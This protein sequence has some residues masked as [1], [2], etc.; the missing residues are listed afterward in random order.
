MPELK[1]NFLKGKMNK[2]LDER[3]V[4]NGEYRDA[5]NI[6]ISTSEGSDVGSAQ[7]LKGNTKVTILNQCGQSFMGG[8]ISDNAISVGS[9]VD[10]NDSK[11][12]NF[13]YRAS[14]LEANGTYGSYTVYTGVRSDVITEYTPDV[15]S[16]S[17]VTFPILTDIYDVRYFADEQTTASLIKGLPTQTI[18]PCD[19]DSDL[20]AK[21]I[22]PGMRVQLMSPE[23]IDYY[24]EENKVYVSKVIQGVLSNE[25]EVELTTSQ[26]IP[27]YT[28]SLKDSGFVFKFSSDKILNFKT[29]TTEIESNTNEVAKSYT[30][31]NNIITG[32]NLINDILFFTDGRNEPKKVSINNFKNSKNSITHH[33]K[34]R[35]KDINGTAY[36]YSLKEE[37]ITVIKRNP[38]NSIDVELISTN[39]PSTQI[40]DEL[41]E[42]TGFTYA[43]TT[44]SAIL[45]LDNIDSNYGDLF[46]LTNDEGNLLQN[47]DDIYIIALTERVHWKVNDIINI[48]GQTNSETARIKVTSTTN[49]N[50][51]FNRFTCQIIGIDDSYTGEEAAEAW[52]AVLI[53][54][55]KFYEEKFIS[56]AYRYKYIDNEYSCIS[57]Y[58]KAI[59]KP[60]VYN[61]DSNNGF[62]KGMESSLKGVILSN[63]RSSTIPDDVVEIELLFQDHSSNTLN[64]IN[65]IKKE[66]VIGSAWRENSITI[67]SE[68]FGAT[69]PSDQLSRIYDN[70]PRSAVAQE[71]S[72]SR[73]MYGNYVENYDL[74]DGNFKKIKP[75]ISSSIYS[76]NNNFTVS[77]DLDNSVQQTH[78]NAI[79]TYPNSLDAEANGLYYSFPA[80][81]GNP[82]KFKM[83]LGNDEAANAGPP[84]SNYNIIVP[85]FEQRILVPFN[86]EISDPQTRFDNEKYFYTAASSDEI[87]IAASCQA[88]STVRAVDLNFGAAEWQMQKIRLT[89]WRVDS[90]A[91]RISKIHSGPWVQTLNSAGEL[92][93]A[94]Y[95]GTIEPGL[96]TYSLLSV[97]KTFN[98]TA[99]YNYAIFLEHETLS[100]GGV[101]ELLAEENDDDSGDLYY[102]IVHTQITNSSISIQATSTENN[103]LSHGATESIKTLRSY[104]LGVVYL[105]KH[106]RES[107]IIFDEKDNLTNPVDNSD[108]KNRLKTKINHKAPYWAT[109]YKFY[110][111]EI[112]R[113]FS[114]AVLHKAYDNDASG[115]NES[116][117]YIW[118]S[119]NSA[120][121]DKISV[122]DYLIGKKEHGLNVAVKSENAKWRVLEKVDNPTP[123]S[124][125]NEYTVGSTTLNAEAEDVNGKFFVKINN[126][127]YFSSLIGSGDNLTSNSYSANGAVF[128]VQ[129][130]QNI[131]SDLFYEISEAY[132][133]K[134]EGNYAKD[135]IDV[136]SIVS[137]ENA[138]YLTQNQIQQFNSSN[139]KVVN[140]KG[141]VSLG[142]NQ[143]NFED[144]GKCIVTIDSLIEFPIISDSQNPVIFRFTRPD[145]SYV[146]CRSAATS[147][148]TTLKIYPYTHK[149]SYNNFSSDIVLPWINCYSFGNGVES[150]RIRDDFNASTI[151]LYTENG[152]Q[153]GF[154][155]NFPVNDYKQEVKEN[156]IIYSQVI[157]ES[158]GLNRTNEFLSGLNIVKKI[159]PEFGSIQ[160]LYSRNTDLI[161]LC[162]NKVL[163]VLAQKNALFNADGTNQL[164]SSNNVL[165]Q[166]I[167]YSGDFGISKNPES[168]A[169]DEYRIYFAD[170]A[171]GS[172]CRLSMDG[173]T[174]ISEAGMK[175]WFNDN[176]EYANSIIGSFDD[177]KNEYNVT[178]HS[179][180]SP[181]S[182]KNVYTLSYSEDAKG[183]T[184]FKSFIPEQG[185]SLANNYY[186]FKNGKMWLHHPDKT[187]TLRNNFY[188]NQ[189]TSSITPLFNDNPGLIKNFNVINYE[190]TQ[191]KVKKFTD[192]LVDAVT[193]ND[194]EYYN[195]AAINGWYVDDIFTDQQE[196]LVDEFI[197]KEGKWF[198][199]IKGVA[200]S[201]TNAADA[202][203]ASGNIDFNEF[204]VQGIGLLSIDATVGEGETEPS[205]GYNIDINFNGTGWSSSGYQLYN[206]T[207]VSENG[208]FEITPN[209]AFSLSASS[210]S[211]DATEYSSI[212]SITFADSTSPNASD[213][214]IQG[215][216]Q[217][218]DG[219]TLSENL[220]LNISLSAVSIPITIQYQATL[221]IFGD[222]SQWAQTLSIN[223]SAGNPLI[224][225]VL[226][227]A[228][229]SQ[230]TY[231]ISFF[232]PTLSEVDILDISVSAGSTIMTSNPSVEILPDNELEN[233]DVSVS[234]D[235]T[236]ANIVISYLSQL[237]NITSLDNNNTINI[238]LNYED[239]VCEFLA[240]N[241]TFDDASL[242]H[243]IP[244]NNNYGIPSTEVTYLNGSGWITS[245]IEQQDQIIVS[246]QENTGEDRTAQ[247]ELFSSING[248]AVADSSILLTQSNG[249]TTDI[250]LATFDNGS[251]TSS[252]N[253]YFESLGDSSDS[254]TGRKLYNYGENFKVFCMFFPHPVININPLY[255]Q[256]EYQQQDNSGWISLS[257]EYNDV[258]HVELEF[259]ALE[260][261]GEERS[262]IIRILNP[263]DTTSYDQA[264]VTQRAA[265]DAS[266]NT[267]VLKK[268]TNV[269]ANIISLADAGN[270]IEIGPNS[271][272]SGVQ[273]LYMQIPVADYIDVNGNIHYPTISKSSLTGFNNYSYTNQN[274]ENEFD[275]DLDETNLSNVFLSTDLTSGLG[276]SQTIVSGQQFRFYFT[277]DSNN[278]NVSSS[279]YSGSLNVP[280]LPAMPIDRYFTIYASNPFN[281]TS[282]AD[283]SVTIKQLPLAKVRIENAG[284]AL[285]INSTWD[286]SSI[287][288]DAASNRGLPIAL[289]NRWT[290]NSYLVYDEWSGG[291]SPNWINGISVEAQS[292]DNPY[293]YNVIVSAET[294][295]TNYDRSIEIKLKSPVD[296]NVFV[297]KQIKFEKVV[298]FLT[299]SNNNGIPLTS[300]Q[301]S[302]TY[303]ADFLSV[304]SGAYSY[305]INNNAT[306]TPI[307]SEVQYIDNAESG[308]WVL[309]TP[310]WI[311]SGPTIAEV[312]GLDK[313]NFTLSQNTTGNIR[314][315][316]IK[317]QH[318]NTGIEVTL[319]AFQ[320]N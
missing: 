16:E 267:L 231:N 215:T 42:A 104:Q 316:I 268:D 313:L 52:T 228:T 264:L 41:G 25:G 166:I 167:P 266:V 23:G 188:E 98:A 46:K 187:T 307:V 183:W 208:L 119:F 18:D 53:E 242:S 127:E 49:I 148:G 287:Y 139:Y 75:A 101:S 165:G 260:N 114:N 45:R 100:S 223:S 229:D 179:I 195:E 80:V 94:T 304:L 149:T 47:G 142:Y 221:N 258:Y 106:G 169:V 253:I 96:A 294:N 151:F 102:S 15:N 254:S 147:S 249:Q 40:L 295:W 28:Q 116:S 34:L 122:G 305:I 210:F 271:V 245:I 69:I 65:S 133:I 252:Q 118:L 131:D 212:E 312:D 138:S 36:E 117:L 99:G 227:N 168:F 259:S 216:I 110:V 263:D 265:Y 175:D 5:L 239:G 125:D 238:Y 90:N 58:S 39:R 76:L 21:G 202:G 285:F 262:A 8:S 261:T 224:V 275:I 17:G 109:H 62:N 155:A 152:K 86:N 176:I 81:L 10:E 214:V 11:I 129:R 19:K 79:S 177:K 9:Y 173:I 63:F 132:P 22:R 3:L 218:V 123:T 160:K 194:G 33:S 128:E 68:V 298:A 256:I 282:T 159:S 87:S 48:T 64:S 54:K 222:F 300:N 318:P 184:S 219:L 314:G 85:D 140:V 137:I 250:K 198:N 37:H 270:Q 199:Y 72:A 207:T 103:I 220:T 38:L 230:Q 141:A 309:G 60:G 192:E 124:T 145:G 13:I 105:D 276:A 61:Y 211:F 241:I 248:S 200:T 71:I 279:T 246:L 281:N 311:S 190:G 310:S 6:E 172:I 150:D 240:P 301:E 70:V 182:T 297:L 317:I 144:I 91:N 315:L 251:Y 237:E 162:E 121:K 180:L 206:V 44:T 56:F 296:D 83:I 92:A 272:G 233:Y 185:V 4:P 156:D 97:S 234:S 189:Y 135:F 232:I 51:E 302:N 31:Y 247:I 112:A 1:R 191:S 209:P 111:K 203:A 205:F 113:D 154:K 73:L 244:I 290:N 67:S 143:V 292:Q 74:K 50:N 291:S 213:N 319:I 284:N 78:T 130:D 93:T 193:Y 35:Y 217:F 43:N 126:D 201:F 286:G 27:L 108:L 30:P 257:N 236:N 277:I 288:L 84:D 95:L 204:S 171:R 136:N 181:L 178:I 59:F 269:N 274:L 186:T 283:D 225:P 32:I 29:G 14:D 107:T 164:I 146:T 134:L 174:P 306:S 273:Y 320:A 153:S 255:I 2:D 158:I 289:V 57:P 196:G 280:T 293:I 20:V 163:K 115:E 308:N 88:W 303:L 197:N 278:S 170:K 77:I 243:S 55:S 226:A 89:I 161:V 299:I 26:S 157:N 120:D 12:Y 82:I 24:G 66:G 7:N 235:F